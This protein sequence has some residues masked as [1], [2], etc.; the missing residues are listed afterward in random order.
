MLLRAELLLVPVVPKLVP[1]PLK[2]VLVLF[3]SA[4]RSLAMPAP[5]A[6]SRL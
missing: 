5:A 6:V 1:L 2:T 4:S 3:S